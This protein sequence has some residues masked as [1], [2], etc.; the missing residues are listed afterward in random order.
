MTGR[1]LV[2]KAVLFQGPERL[3]YTLPEEFGSDMIGTGV[4]PDPAWKPSFLQLI[5]NGKMNG[6]VSGKG[7]QETFQKGRLQD[8]H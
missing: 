8:I 4:G 2:T 3:P 1:E 6:I 5:Q 7:F